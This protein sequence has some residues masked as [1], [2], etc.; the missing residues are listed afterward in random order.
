MRE[1]RFFDFAIATDD[2]PEDPA[3]FISV[4]CTKASPADPRPV[5]P[6]PSWSGLY[7][8]TVAWRVRDATT[9]VLQHVH[10]RLS[11]RVVFSAPICARPL[12][13][14][15]LATAPAGAETDADAEDATGLLD[16]SA[17]VVCYARRS[18]ATV[19]HLH[20]ARSLQPAPA[21]PVVVESAR[22]F[23]HD[24]RVSAVLPDTSAVTPATAAVL[25][26]SDGRCATVALHHGAPAPQLRAFHPPP[27]P[28][29]A[30]SLASSYDAARASFMTR[31]FSPRATDATFS[32]LPFV[33]AAAT[34]PL[35]PFYGPVDPVLALAAVP[36][37]TPAVAS[38]HR[39]GRVCIFAKRD[40]DY[41]F[42][43]D[44]ILP[45]KLSESALDHFLVTGSDNCVLALV[46]TDEHPKTDSL[47]VFALRVSS[48]VDGEVPLTC[49]Q[50]V[51][52]EGPIPRIIAAAYFAEDVVVATHTGIVTGTINAPDA[53][54]DLRDRSNGL[55]SPNDMELSGVS[56]S[57]RKGLPTRMLWTALDDIDEPYGLGR[58]IARAEGNDRS[59]L[60]RAHRFSP[61]AIAKALRLPD[62]NE[63]TRRYV[64][65]AIAQFEVDDHDV[66]WRKVKSR[67]EQVSKTEDLRLLD[68]SWDESVGLVIARE[69]ALHILRP[70][71]DVEKKVY[72]GVDGMLSVDQDTPHGPTAWLLSSHAICQSLGARYLDNVDDKK[73]FF[74]LSLTS[75][76]S[77]TYPDI[78]LTDLFCIKRAEICAE[79]GKADA[80][81]SDIM[82]MCHDMFEPGSM[83]LGALLSTLEME[84]LGSAAEHCV[85]ELPIS[86]MFANGIVWLER[87]QRDVDMRMS[88]VDDNGVANLLADESLKGQSAS[89]M[90]KKAYG[91]FVFASQHCGESA[92]RDDVFCAL[93]LAGYPCKL[94][95]A[96]DVDMDDDGEWRSWTIPSTR[97]GS[98]DDSN[99]DENIVLGDCAFWLLERVLRMMEGYSAPKTAAAA[100]LEAMKYAPDKEKHERMRA[101]A[102][103]HY[104]EA[105]ELSS[106]LKA[107][108]SAPFNREFAEETSVEEAE[109]LKDSIGLF[110]NATADQNRLKWLGEQELPEPLYSLCGQALERRARGAEV[111]LV[112][113]DGVWVG[114]EGAADMGEDGEVDEGCLRDGSEYE[115]L[116]AWHVLRGD[117]SSAAGSALERAERLS[118]EGPD[119]IRMAVRT[120]Q[121]DRSGLDS[122]E[123][124]MRQLLNWTIAKGDALSA[125]LSAMSQLATDRRYVTR[126][127]S[128]LATLNKNV[129]QD[130]H[131]VLY[132]EWVARRLLLARVQRVYLS[133]VLVGHRKAG[134]DGRG[135]E[136]GGLKNVDHLAA[137]W[138]PFLSE[139]KGGVEWIS[140]M[141]RKEAVYDVMLLCAELCSAWCGEIG[142]GCVSDVV[143]GAARMAAR[144]EVSCFSYVDLDQLLHAVCET[145]V[146]CGSNWYL[147]ALESALSTCAGR[148][149]L[150][151]WL[152][153]CAAHGVSGPRGAGTADGDGADDDGGMTRGVCGEGDLLG[154]VKALLRNNRPVDAGRVLINGLAEAERKMR[155]GMTMPHVSYSAIDAVLETLE[156]MAEDYAEAERVHRVLADGVKRHLKLVG[157]THDRRWASA[158]QSMADGVS[159][160][161]S[162]GVR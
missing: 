27:L 156:Q 28:P 29:A 124:Y 45:C 46:M 62:V 67:A 161:G 118:V 85:D 8:R 39:S 51:V 16:I 78:P 162:V 63:A 48:D 14:P 60:L 76:F 146:K 155:G 115:D 143:S 58:A 9:L 88:G 160:D 112:K 24:V 106:A 61:S 126:F 50:L 121:N 135:G 104:L 116:Y 99:A 138:N 103:S 11:L 22:H 82:A 133:D 77:E 89:E 66:A 41:Q 90:L 15:A 20:I 10:T 33:P 102:F 54:S 25:A 5:T 105:G 136:G 97:N 123:I 17:V 72:P 47:R 79:D 2:S 110:I 55:S 101:A 142:N 75:K 119:V 86:A 52:R 113:V 154:V 59:Q 93:G 38:L 42:A 1:T 4:P 157:D 83:L 13:R 21:R 19:L 69:K 159:V 117:Y 109:A 81:F 3:I 43:A 127:S 37:S 7:D 84:S 49:T 114:D 94:P 139:D 129:D 26:L 34:R 140:A 87:Y 100:A 40:G 150:P 57:S 71:F 137:E 147:I 141:L 53:E 23:L 134:S 92:R 96:G 130:L 149:S 120:M 125:A 31:F 65:S 30:E 153:D 6:T 32:R 35:P 151:Q 18:G 12:L 108:L 56:P 73:V 36:C 74:T 152:V 122:V 64:D 144:K 80:S 131:V 68:L 111:F 70:L 44:C 107:I 145:N 132:P 91:F 148:A 95:S 158:A 98:V 128:R